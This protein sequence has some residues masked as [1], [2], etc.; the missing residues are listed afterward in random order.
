MALDIG[1][2]GTNVDDGEVRPWMAM[3][4]WLLS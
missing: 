1:S 4:L 2:S 3:A